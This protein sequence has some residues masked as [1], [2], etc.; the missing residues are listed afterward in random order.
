L[1]PC[2]RF[3]GLPGSHVFTMSDMPCSQT[4]GK[5]RRLAILCRFCVDFRYSQS[6]ILPMIVYF[7]AQSL[8]PCGLRPTDLLSYA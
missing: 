1:P 3:Q 5:L 4:P 2:K 6:V 7:E 8:Q